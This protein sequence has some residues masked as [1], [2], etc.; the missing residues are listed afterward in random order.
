[1][2]NNLKRLKMPENQHYRQHMS[3]DERSFAAAERR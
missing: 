2:K 1:M 3:Y